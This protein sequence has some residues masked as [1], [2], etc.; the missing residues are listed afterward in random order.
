QTSSFL[1]YLNGLISPNGKTAITE[2]IDGSV[3]IRR[4]GSPG[5]ITRGLNSDR[6]AARNEVYGVTNLYLRERR[7]ISSIDALSSPLRSI[8]SS[9]ASTRAFA[10]VRGKCGWSR[11]SAGSGASAFKVSIF[12]SR[13]P[14]AVNV[15]EAFGSR[16]R[17]IQVCSEPPKTAASSGY[18]ISVLAAGAAESRNG[19]MGERPILE[20]NCWILKSTGSVLRSHSNIPLALPSCFR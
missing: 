11:D 19:L 18:T 12:P 6:G 5:R 16:Y 20:M 4:I 13:T 14:V 8:F 15:V 10:H 17:P 9:K 1:R 3:L 7:M 2:R